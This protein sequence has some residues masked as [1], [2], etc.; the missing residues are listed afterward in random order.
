M[1][2][3]PSSLA[4]FASVF[5]LVVLFCLKICIFLKVRIIYGFVQ[6]FS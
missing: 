3:I 6:D 1:R 4:F 5:C 2:V